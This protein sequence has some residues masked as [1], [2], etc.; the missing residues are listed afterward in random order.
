[1][2]SLGIFIG[3]NLLFGIKAGVDNSAH[4]GG[5]VSGLLTGIILYISLKQPQNKVREKIVLATL[6]GLTLA[7]SVFSMSR[8]EDPVGEYVKIMAKYSECEERA[9]NVYRLPDSTNKELLLTEFNNTTIPNLDRCNEEMQKLQ[10]LKLPDELKKRVDILEQ[11]TTLR[12]TEANLRKKALV[13]NT[14]AYNEAIGE[15][16]DKI[17][18]I[19]AEINK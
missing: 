12:R 6:I 18:K 8:I 4:I 2:P 7:G 15:E 14:D 1:L 17:N 10:K 13:E 3:Y 5:L 16:V 11:Y 19:L 9:L